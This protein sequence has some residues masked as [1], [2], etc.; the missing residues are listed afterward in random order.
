LSR[1]DNQD[2]FESRVVVFDGPEDYHQRLN[3]PALGIDESTM[4]VV[5]GCGTIGFPGSGEVVNMQPPDSLLKVGVRELPTMEM[6][7]KAELRPVGR[8]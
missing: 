6:A 7:G 3:D 4:H 8:F 2:C 1:S 5:R